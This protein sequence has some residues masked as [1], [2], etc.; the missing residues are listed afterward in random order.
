M[1]L[2]NSIEQN[3]AWEANISLSCSGSLSYLHG[4]TTSSYPRPEEPNT[5]VQTPFPLD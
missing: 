1:Y 4:L 3:P 2:T 5:G